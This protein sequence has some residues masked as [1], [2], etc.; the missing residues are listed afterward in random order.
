VHIVTSR[1]LRDAYGIAH[2]RADSDME[3]FEL[4]GYQH[5]ADRL[6]SMEVARLRCAGRWAEVAGPEAVDADSLS[7]RLGGRGN[8]ERD[9]LA[10]G[11]EAQEM[12]R[13]YVRGVNRCIAEGAYDRTE[14]EAAAVEPEAWTPAD[15][16]SVARRRWF[17][18]GSVWFK[19]WRSIV[20]LSRP[21]LDAGRFRYHTSPEESR[22]VP[23]GSRGRRVEIA[24]EA[25]QRLSAVLH[26]VFV[27]QQTGGGSNSFVLAGSRTSTGMPIVAGDP[28]MVFE[29]PGMLYQMHLRAESFD[30]VGF[31]VPGVPGFPHFAHNGTVAWGLTHAFADIHDLYVHVLGELDVHIAQHPQ[32]Y[33][34]R[35]ETV[36]VRGGADVTVEIVETPQGP[37]ITDRTGDS[38]AGALSLKSA[39]FFDADLSFEGELARLRSSSTTEFLDAMADWGLLDFNMVCADV[40]GSIEYATRARVPVRPR[41]NGILPVPASDPESQW[42]GYVPAA[43]LPR[44]KNPEA[45]YFVTANSRICESLPDGTYFCT[46][47]HP[48]YR[49]D[50][51][52]ELIESAEHITPEQAHGFLEDR[53]STVALEALAA[54]R[55]LLGA[56]QPEHPRWRR[57]HAWNGHMDPDSVEA[58]DYSRIRWALA[59]RLLPE[60]RI[61]MERNP[62]AAALPRPDEQGVT[63][64]WWMLPTMLRTDGSGVI[65]KRRLSELLAESVHAVLERSPETTWGELHRVTFLPVSGPGLFAHG[66]EPDG[67][68]VGGDNET[69]LCTGAVAAGGQRAVYGPVAK[70]VF[71]L[72][73]LRRS[74]WI[75]H[76][77]IAGSPTAPSAMSQHQDW[78][79]GRQIPMLYD[80]DEIAQ[81]AGQTSPG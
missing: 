41:E 42:Q 4:Q 69:V 55:R 15:P 60:M 38:A 6:W 67:A 24:S 57:M 46:D 5:A 29:F 54:F 27:P 44:Q 59:A 23:A 22:V 49:A 40:S 52:V 36:R 47:A 51:L 74:T 75:S 70:Y 14:F 53:K 32:E 25:V 13:A 48:S 21:D 12:L 39:Q 3:A 72:A 2:L 26:D 9:F 17:L 68:R 11:A 35:E 45:G 30:A 76:T 1:I 64:I 50:R 31:T 56:A 37:L 19:V 18:M 58:A 8:A 33:R 16:I 62:A 73:D 43:R 34:V 10:L 79:A 61:V 71:D 66:R 63:D 7:R 65:Q 20:A 78:A 77:G 81:Q 80:W 28:H